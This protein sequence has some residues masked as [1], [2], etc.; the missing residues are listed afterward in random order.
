MSSFGK[1][2]ATAAP[3]PKSTGGPS[4]DSA[5][6][7]FR[8]SFRLP[9]PGEDVRTR[10]GIALALFAFAAP[11]CAQHSVDATADTTTTVDAAAISRDVA[12]LAADSMEGRAAG[13]PGGERARRYLLERFQEIGL[14]PLGAN[15]F[16]HVF[17]LGDGAATRTGVNLIGAVP[18]TAADDRVILVTAHYDHLGIRDG[19]IFNGADDNAS[20][21]AG[22]LE[23]AR[24]FVVRPPAHPI[25]FV[26]F[27]A[28]EGGLRGARAFVERQPVELERIALIVNLDM[29]GRNDAGELYVAG[30]AHYPALE[31]MV[32]DI[33]TN[34]PVRLL[35]GHDRPGPTPADDWTHA[36][37]HGPFHQAGVPFLYFGVEDHPDY[38]RPTDDADR[39]QP[40]FHARAV[41]TVLRTLLALDA[42]PDLLASIRP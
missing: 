25:V 35:K 19:V 5:A 22:L 34:A 38:H 6:L 12:V 21:V 29:I 28:E 41:D 15:G 27:D 2:S 9:N 24:Q 1:D 20:G 39:I 37:D 17:R 40:D 3:N 30:T 26:A 13:S 33:A 7:R 8:I 14:R 23:L 32:D 18:G 11:A 42:M 31:P 36:S 4:A 16:E 10:A